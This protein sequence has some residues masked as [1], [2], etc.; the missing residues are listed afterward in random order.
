[1][2]S[3]FTDDRPVGG[4]FGTGDLDLALGGCLGTGG[5]GTGGDFFGNGDGDG[6]LGGGGFP[7]GGA[8]DGATPDPFAAVGADAAMF[9]ADVSRGPSSSAILPTG[10]SSG[11][12]GGAAMFK[13]DSMT[14]SALSSAVSTSI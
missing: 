7:E 5:F 2:A 3:V 8:L 13:A 14:T 9:T 4:I 12:G 10:G 6:S 11:A 1:M